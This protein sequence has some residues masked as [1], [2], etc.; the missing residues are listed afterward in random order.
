M[1]FGFGCRGMETKLDPG[2]NSY[3]KFRIKRAEGG[4]HPLDPRIEEDQH[5]CVCG[6]VKTTCGAVVFVT[7]LEPIE[8]AAWRSCMNLTSLSEAKAT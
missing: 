7:D 6:T 5:V 4:C 8:V 1:E 3:H 2:N